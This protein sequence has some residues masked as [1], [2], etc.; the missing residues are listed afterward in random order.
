MMIWL[1]IYF[2]LYLWDSIDFFY[3]KHTFD[4]PVMCHVDTKFPLD[5]DSLVLGGS[6]VI[7]QDNVARLKPTPDILTTGCEVSRF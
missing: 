2:I 3:L 1:I 4:Y 7:Y 5:S 6:A